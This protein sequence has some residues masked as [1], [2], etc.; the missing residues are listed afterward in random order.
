MNYLLKGVALASLVL[1]FS[2]CSDTFDPTS[3]QDGRLVLDVNVDHGVAAP[4]SARKNAPSRAASVIEITANDLRLA[5]RSTSGDFAQS[6]ENLSAFDPAINFPVGNYVFEASYGTKGQEGFDMPYYFGSTQLSIRENQTTPVSVTASLANAMVSV[7]Y[8]DAFKGYFSKYTT[9]LQTASGT[10]GFAADETRA[11]YVNAGH[12]EVFANVTKPNGINAKL[13]AISFQ[14]EPRHHYVVTLDV[15][16][17]SG[18]LNITFNSDTVTEEIDIDVTDDVLAAPAPT[19]SAEGFTAGEAITVVEGS[20][21]ADKVRMIATA[22]GE[23]ATG[24]LTTNSDALYAKRW[25][26]T[27]DFNTADA[28]TLAVLGNCGLKQVGFTG[29]KS[30][31]AMLD[32]S[33]VIPTLTYD[34]SSDNTSTFT[35]VAKDKYAKVSEPLTLTIVVEKLQV[36]VVSTEPL[37]AGSDELSFTVA[38]NGSNIESSLNVELANARGT[39]DNAAIKKIEPAESSKARSSLTNYNVTIAVPSTGNITFRCKSGSITT[40]V[41]TAERIGVSVAD[42]NVFATSATATFANGNSSNIEF[43]LAQSGGEF[44]KI[45]PEVSGNVAR[46]SG[47]KAATN[48]SLKLKVNGTFTPEASFTTEAATQLPNGDME[49][50]SVKDSAS[51]WTNYI[52]GA[53]A[54]TVWGTNNDM[55]TQQGSNNAYQK[56]SGTI[57][58]TDAHGVSKAAQLRTVGWGSG[59]TAVGSANQKYSDAGLLH[60]GANRTGR[61]DNAKDVEGLITTDDLDCGIAFTSRPSS[62]SFWYKYSKKHSDDAGLVEV[63]VK[64]TSGNILASGTKQLTADSYTQETIPLNY[65]AGAAKAAK[66]YVKFLSTHDRT[67]LAASKDYFDVPGFATIG[68]DKFVGSSLY[69]DDIVLNY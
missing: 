23:I 69:I 44:Q 1:G 18:T 14:A 21:L 55:T 20:S 54:T 41:T 42:A 59:N 28:P 58:S 66:L 43:Y 19:L 64:D 25:P 26:A 62:V 37:F 6:W 49:A 17:G 29:V 61:P 63:W 67:F 3:D 16:A 68:G 27:V 38:Y 57:E 8:T 56:I 34:E 60:L 48:Y 47:L 4:E 7:V 40:A 9:D 10:V 36:E 45:S 52:V 30:Q 39:W 13:S 24:V 15:E 31:M 53:D 32:F 5:L 22:Y 2:A 12:I 33:E 65:S 50:W 51:K 11:A 46:L 35:L